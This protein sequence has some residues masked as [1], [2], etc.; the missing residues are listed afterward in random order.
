[1]IVPKH[2]E[3]IHVLHENTMPDR[4]YYI[5]A[6]KVIENLEENRE[7]SDRFLLLNGMWKFKYYSSIYELTDRF[8]EENFETADYKQVL[9]PGVWQNYGYDCWQYTNIRYPFPFDPPY[10][11]CDNPCGTYVYDFD[12]SACK[13][14]PKAYLN[15]EGVDS[16][17]YVW[18]NGQYAGYSQVSHSTSEFDVTDFLKRRKKSSGGACLKMVR[19]KLHG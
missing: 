5:P 16:C 3:N 8:Y 15:F 18:V 19:R 17:F 2:Y 11:P 10:V 7:A 4:S 1:M 6:S 13:E 9:V 12:Y 14:A